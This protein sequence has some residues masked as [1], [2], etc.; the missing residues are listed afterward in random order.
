MGTPSH[1]SAE[2]PRYDLRDLN[3]QNVASLRQEVGWSWGIAALAL[4]LTSVGLYKGLLVTGSGS[5]GVPAGVALIGI[6]GL[7][8]FAAWLGYPSVKRYPDFLTIGSEEVT[9]GRT[10][11]PRI[12]RIRWD[13]P[14]LYFLLVDRSGVPPPKAPKVAMPTFI[15]T[16]RNSRAL[17]V[18]QA[19]FEALI[20]EAEKH[21]LH[22]KHTVYSSRFVRSWGTTKTLTITPSKGHRPTQ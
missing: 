17:P 2:A 8:Y 11:T 3:V 6:S 14:T 20:A 7:F 1:S 4:F 5:I 22:V 18:P 21:G 15:V 16:P 12:T 19:A 9:Y 10:G 13:D